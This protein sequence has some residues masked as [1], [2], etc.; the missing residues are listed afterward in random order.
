MP[1]SQ[2]GGRI[3]DPRSDDPTTVGIVPSDRV[4]PRTCRSR[5]GRFGRRGDPVFPIV[6]FD[7]VL[8]RALTDLLP[9]ARSNRSRRIPYLTMPIATEMR[10]YRFRI[11]TSVTPAT[12]ATSFWVQGLLQR[13]AEM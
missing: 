11:V 7:L 6:R 4:I 8:H 2:R 12:S 1:S 5:L 13:I 3:K 9:A 10:L